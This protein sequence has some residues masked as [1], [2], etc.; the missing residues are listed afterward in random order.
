MSED[1]VTRRFRPVEP[2]RLY[3]SGQT[4]PADNSPEHHCIKNRMVLV[5]ASG[6]DEGSQ[7]CSS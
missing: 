6:T 5:S 4:T 7:A 2:D 1:L 3:I